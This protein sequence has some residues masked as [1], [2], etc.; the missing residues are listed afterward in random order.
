MARWPP[1]MTGPEV[2]IWV[3]AAVL[4]ARRGADDAARNHLA[5]ARELNPLLEQVPIPEGGP[6]LAEL[7]MAWGEPDEA[8]AVLERS[9]P[10]REF[11]PI[12]HGLAA[13]RGSTRD[14]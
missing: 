11:E 2:G 4:A 1:A 12:R 10:F 7:S 8:F 3:S 13:G 6:R 9:L 14:R 5:R